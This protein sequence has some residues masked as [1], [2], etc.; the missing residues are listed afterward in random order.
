[1][2]EV[3]DIP[4]KK[5]DQ[6]NQMIWVCSCGCSTFE[7]SIKA[8]AHCSACGAPT[9]DED[10]GWHVPAVERKWQGE[11]PFQDICGNGSLEFAKRRMA[12]RV[13]DPGTCLIVVATEDGSVSAWSRAET[14][15]QLDWVD[16][17]LDDAF[18]LVQ[19]FT[20][21]MGDK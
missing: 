15:E 2:G 3:V 11:E 12:Q 16:E 7:L 18:E 8:I 10:G 14:Q 19:K 9:I 4:E 20:A 6:E 13:T 21:N 1:M 5:K 17:K